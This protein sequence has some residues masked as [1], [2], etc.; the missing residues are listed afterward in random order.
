[1]AD[2]WVSSSVRQTATFWVGEASRVPKSKKI[3]D[4][5]TPNQ[6]STTGVQTSRTWL[7]NMGQHGFAALNL[8]FPH[9]LLRSRPLNRSPHLQLV[10][11]FEEVCR[12]RWRLPQSSSVVEPEPE[13]KNGDTWMNFTE[14]DARF[15]LFL[16]S[17]WNRFL[18]PSNCKARESWL[19]SLKISSE[20]QLK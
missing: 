20:L 3:R 13:K 9:S 12:T 2:C 10:W 6:G 18:L 4:P 11:R 1:M 7:D 15:D 8:N 5:N 19:Y 16:L 17:W 14:I